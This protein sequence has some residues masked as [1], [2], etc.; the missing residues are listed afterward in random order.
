MV[1]N[2]LAISKLRK[3]NYP[4]ILVKPIEKY[5]AATIIARRE[6]RRPPPITNLLRNKSL[7]KKGEEEGDYT[8][9]E[10]ETLNEYYIALEND[11]ESTYLKLKADK[12]SKAELS[13]INLFDYMEPSNPMAY[14]RG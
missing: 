4:E 5:M 2:K 6:K 8:P 7:I 3:A 12:T 14:I 11:D 9:W 13:D 10:L 1:K